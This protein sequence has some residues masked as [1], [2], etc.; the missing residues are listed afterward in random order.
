MKGQWLGTYKGTQAGTLMV[1]IDE[2][3]GRY[4]IFAYLIPDQKTSL[5]KIAIISTDDTAPKQ[6]VIAKLLPVD[7]KT[8]YSCK[9]SDIEGSHLRPEDYL[10]E[11][12]ITLDAK[13]NELTITEITAE[14]ISFS[15]VLTKRPTSS[16]SRIKGTE[17]SWRDF[18]LEVSKFSD[19]KFLFRGQEKNWPL[20]TSFH[21]GDRY[22]INE[23]INKDVRQLHQR[24][25][26]ITSHYFDLNSPD[27][28]G[29]FINLMQ[30]HGYPTPLLDWTYSPYVSAFFAFRDWSIGHDSKERTRIYIFD[31]EAW[32]KIF[33]QTYN[34]NPTFPHL[35]VMEFIALENPRLVPQQ[36]VTTVTNIDDIET[37]ILEKEKEAKD[38][39]L[40]AFDIPAS[41]RAIA[42]HDLRI[43]GITAGSMFP[44]LDGVCEE[45]KERNFK[46]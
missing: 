21:R 31:N 38:K 39:F 6:E 7:P 30:H 29:S 35:S 8:G 13:E 5:R 44:G 18:K 14:D 15:S 9:W 26:A 33:P 46:K 40:Y 3:H 4:E 16:K 34:L 36:S 10:E 23:F 2:V 11:A 19:G 32:Q 37:Y 45:L 1:N 43:M 17:I 28:N 27:Q 24:L 20:R 22:R 42:M 12:S 41:E 25:S